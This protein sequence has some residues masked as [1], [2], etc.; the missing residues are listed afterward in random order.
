MCTKE[1]RQSE[2]SFYQIVENW[3]AAQHVGRESSPCSF[4]PGLLGSWKKSC[5]VVE[6]IKVGVVMSQPRSPEQ[7]QFAQTLLV[8]SA[9]WI[10]MSSSSASR[11]KLWL[12][13][14]DIENLT[15]AA[16]HQ[17]RTNNKH[18]SMQET[19][20]PDLVR[21]FHD[22]PELKKLSCCKEH[23]LLAASSAIYPAVVGVHWQG[24]IQGFCFLC[25]NLFPGS[26]RCC[27]LTH[28][29]GPADSTPAK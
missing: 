29:L 2:Y 27:F 9:R 18:L 14:E 15:F 13:L 7:I 25:V 23:K 1:N 10:K 12:C 6:L 5:Q 22:Y 17:L 3:A 20:P 8:R 19:E 28:S 4:I 11:L 21:Q 24:K 16:T 26:E